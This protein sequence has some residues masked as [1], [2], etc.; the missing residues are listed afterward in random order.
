MLSYNDIKP[1]RI[2]E[3]DGQPYQVLSS[4]VS[5]KQQQKPVNKTRLKHLINGNV[6]EHTFQHS[7]NVDEANVDRKDIRYLFSKPNRQAGTT[8][9][10]F[11]NADNSSNRFMLDES[12][13]E[14]TKNFLKENEL[15]QALAVEDIIVS[16]TPPIKMVLE[17]TEAPPNI[18]GNTASGGNKQVTLETGAVVSTPMFVETGDRIEINTETGEYVRRI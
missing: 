12:I 6:I 8:E 2:I 3:L 17:V 11:G 13:V 14:D 1:K 16:L 18:K 9:Y 7:D 4:N 10:W 5:R 15:I